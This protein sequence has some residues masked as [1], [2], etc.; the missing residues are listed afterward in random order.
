MPR[1]TLTKTVTVDADSPLKAGELADTLFREPWEAKQHQ[2]R[3]VFTVWTH[4]GE[5]HSGPLNI[6]HQKGIIHYE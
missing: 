2:S 3:K 4:A 6:N 1:Y 5:C